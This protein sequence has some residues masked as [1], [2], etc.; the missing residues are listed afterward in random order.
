VKLALDAAAAIAIGQ[1]GS[2]VAL[3]QRHQQAFEDGHDLAQA[4]ELASLIGGQLAVVS[5]EVG[6]DEE[7]IIIRHGFTSMGGLHLDQAPRR[8]EHAA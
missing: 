4:A 8:G 5:K 2:E 1:S 6:K 3:L 7:R